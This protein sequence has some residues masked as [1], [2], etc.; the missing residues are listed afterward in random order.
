MKSEVISKRF[1]RW[2]IVGILIYMPLHVFMSNWLGSAFDVLDIAKVWKD[3][4]VFGIFL[5]FLF[6]ALKDKTLKPLLKNTTVYWVLAYLSL[7]L[8]YTALFHNTTQA[9][10]L[11]L[12]YD[13]RLF[14][15]FFIGVL[16]ARKLG[17]ADKAWLMRW[18]VV[19]AMGVAMLGIV[20]V[21][22]LG[23]GVLSS[24]G[25]NR[26]TG[27]PPAFYI[28]DQTETNERAFATLKDPN[29]LGIY[30]ILPLSLLASS[31]VLQK[32]KLGQGSKQKIIAGCAILL[33]CLALTYS[34]SAAIGLTGAFLVILYKYRKEQ[35]SALFRS[36]K[37]QKMVAGLLIILFAVF[38]VIRNSD[39]VQTTIFHIGEKNSATSNSLR[40]DVLKDS[41]ELAQNKPLGYGVGAAGPVSVKNTGGLA[42]I[43]ENSYLQA[44]L[45]TGIFGFALLVFILIRV[46]KLL[47]TSKDKYA[48]PLL[49]SL[50]GISIAGLFV[51]AWM[52][53]AV[54]YTFWLLCGLVLSDQ[55]M[56][57]ASTKRQRATKR[58]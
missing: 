44:L 31:L 4:A 41:L 43:N 32:N 26:A 54:A 13:A 24:F 5:L 1:V 46:G 53:E 48:L 37:F 50:I 18:A 12:V 22:A 45:E 55:L 27:T 49:A 11:G 40:V 9:R 33:L 7:L 19:V 2:I 36:R 15:A 56:P 52:N 16:A 57:S 35:G 42:I 17:D 30:L 8:L 39:F 6:D 28:N 34:R 14:T 23:N 51:H 3:V 29:S 38:I 10:L 25:Y 21:A 58:P 20:Q 47:S